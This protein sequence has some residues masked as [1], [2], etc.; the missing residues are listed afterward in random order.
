MPSAI[1]HN[2]IFVTAKLS[3]FVLF[4]FCFVLFCFVLFCFV[5]F[6]FVLFCFSHLFKNQ[7][8]PQPRWP[9]FLWVNFFK[10]HFSTPSPLGGVRGMS[11]PPTVPSYATGS[12]SMNF[13]RQPN[14]ETFPSRPITSKVE[15]PGLQIRE[16]V[17]LFE[18]CALHFRTMK[19]A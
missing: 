4:L 9:F 12:W 19:L 2:I 15:C 3:V 5:L 18:F 8:Q 13:G 16:R 6:C 11:C 7:Q 1:A 17:Q 14:R 10:C